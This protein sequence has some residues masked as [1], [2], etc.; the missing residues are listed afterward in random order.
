MSWEGLEV[1]SNSRLGELNKVVYECEPLKVR[2]SCQIRQLVVLGAKC[3]HIEFG[4][5]KWSACAVGVWN[6]A[7]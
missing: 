1:P 6:L 7:S 4:R 3:K 5:E 2:S